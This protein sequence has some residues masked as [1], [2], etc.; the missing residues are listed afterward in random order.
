M[1][2]LTKRKSWDEINV[3]ADETQE[4]YSF[5]HS[6]KLLV[7]KTKQNKGRKKGNEKSEEKK[8]E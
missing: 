8:S 2:V 7:N 5:N 3:G 4:R 6:R 1:S